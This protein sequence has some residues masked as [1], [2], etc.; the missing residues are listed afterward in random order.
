MS[1][2]A[3]AREE[4]RPTADLAGHAPR[5]SAAPRERKVWRTGMLQS[6]AVGVE[7]CEMA[8]WALE[9]APFCASFQRF[10]DDFPRV[11]SR[12]CP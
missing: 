8:L 11:F 1:F 3:P 7:R 12:A 2:R 9:K 4:W 10:F 6:S 5:E